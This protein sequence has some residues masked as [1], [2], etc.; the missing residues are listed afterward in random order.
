VPE[1]IALRGATK[2][3]DLPSRERITPVREVT[4]TIEQGSRTVVT[5]PSGSG[6]TTLL[7]L[8]AGLDVPTSGSVAWPSFDHGPAVPGLIGVVFQAPSLI[9]WLSA[10]ANVAVPL[11]AG[12]V[13]PDEALA[14]A[15]D[16][17]ARFGL[18]DL[19]DRFPSE[20]S[21]GQ[22]QRVALARAL[23]TRPAVVL[24]DEPTGQLD[25]ATGASAI[26]T[27]LDACDEETAVL[28]ATHDER[29]VSRFSSR[30]LMVDGALA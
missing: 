26:D 7:H 24:A 22:A 11:L 13:A 14:R 23:V 4:A 8:C 5:G 6:K 1:L 2:Q 30:W 9:T 16:M 10:K 20:L 19:A 25:G 3:L 18:K 27:L 12:D 17:L 15:H 28:V 21:G 29:I